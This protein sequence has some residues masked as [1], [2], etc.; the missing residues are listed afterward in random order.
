MRRVS[1]I[2]SCLWLAFAG[3]DT[4]MAPARP[5]AVF[6]RHSVTPAVALSTAGEHLAL[7]PADANRPFASVLAVDIDADGDRDAVALDWLS[8]VVIWLND[9]SGHLTRRPEQHASQWLQAAQPAVG[10]AAPASR[11]SDQD[12]HVAPLLAPSRTVHREVVAHAS[13]DYSAFF[14]A[15]PLRRIRSRG[16]PALLA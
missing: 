15:V 13:T 10:G 9:G 2:L 8:G 6:P 1:W 5:T 7:P 11:T 3:L 4:G 16:P 12:D 14:A